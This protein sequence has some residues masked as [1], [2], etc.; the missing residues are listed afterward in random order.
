MSFSE[1]C[2]AEVFWIDVKT[3]RKLLAVLER[4]IMNG[5]I[6]AAA[7]IRIDHYL[8]LYHGPIHR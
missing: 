3:L 5:T 4:F 8:D 6:L 2:E 1:E 7:I